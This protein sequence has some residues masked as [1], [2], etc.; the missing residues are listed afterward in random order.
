MHIKRE[1]LNYLVSKTDRFGESDLKVKKQASFYFN[2][3]LLDY[4]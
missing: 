3:I 2:L 1:T 4:Y